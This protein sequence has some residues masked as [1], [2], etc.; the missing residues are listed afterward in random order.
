MRSI[1]SCL[2]YRKSR[3]FARLFISK[4]RH[5][6]RGID[7]FKYAVI[8]LVDKTAFKHIHQKG[9]SDNILE[10]LFCSCLHGLY[11]P[12]VTPGKIAI[13]AAIDLMAGR[14]TIKRLPAMSTLLEDGVV[15]I[16]YPVRVVPGISTGVGAKAL[17]PSR[18]HIAAAEGAHGFC[19]GCFCR[20][21]PGK[22]LERIAGYTENLLHLCVTHTGPPQ[23]N[24]TIN[25][26]RWHKPS[27]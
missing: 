7:C 13:P 22:R 12:P 8:S 23:R 25:R 11:S 18:E 10:R 20:M 6:F 16:E 3:V 15:C 14:I 24:K 27:L 4:E 2:C 1:L 9:D 19:L 17:L 21:T 26:K 5:I